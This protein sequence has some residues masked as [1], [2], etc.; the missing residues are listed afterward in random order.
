[1]ISYLSSFWDWLRNSAI[2][3]ILFFVVILAAMFFYLSI[4]PIEFIQTS[5]EVKDLVEIDKNTT[6]VIHS[7][8][9][10]DGLKLY[11]NTNTYYTK[12]SKEPEANVQ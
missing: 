2:H 6:Y 11:V 7:E 9:A 3:Q 12:I 5:T 1:M 4:K 10:N 8:I